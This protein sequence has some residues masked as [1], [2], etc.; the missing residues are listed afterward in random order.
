MFILQL[1]LC[2]DKIWPRR[3]EG[4]A[5]GLLIGNDDSENWGLLGIYFLGTCAG[6]VRIQ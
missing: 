5:S 1:N 3:G 4:C 6:V 2:Y